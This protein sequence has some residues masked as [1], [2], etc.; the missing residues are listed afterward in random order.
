MLA[1]SHLI[2][3]YSSIFLLSGSA[4][5]YEVLLMRLFSIIHWHHFAYLIIGLALLGYGVSGTLVSLFQDWLNTRFTTIY[6]LAIMLFAVSSLGSFLLAQSIPFNAEVIFWDPWQWVYLA[7]LFLFL[8]IPFFFAATAICLAFM[9]FQRHTG[10]I[11]AADLVG[12]GT[13][14]LMIIALLFWLAPQQELWIISLIA[15]VAAAIP[16]SMIENQ[17]IPLLL[18]FVALI[19]VLF[20][21][22]GLELKMSPY[23]SLQQTLQITG[24]RL[25]YQQSSP[26]G[27]ID[28][29]ENDSVPFRAASGLS[30]NTP[31]EILP[32]KALFVDGENMTPLN[33]YDGDREPLV[34]L[35]FMTSALPYHLGRIEH[36]LIVG[37]GG[38]SDILQAAYH[39]VPDIQ[40][41]ERNHQVIE[42]VDQHMADYTGQPYSHLASKT[43]A[44]DVRDY[45]QGN[46]AKFDLIQMNLQQASASSAAGLH[47]INESYL[48]TKEAI[49]L[50]RS[51]L[52]TG[53]YLALTRWVTLPPRDIFKLINTLVSS[54]QEEGIDDIDK[55]MLIIRGW[56]TATLILKQ[57]QVTT[58]EIEQVK[59]F[60]QQRSFDLVWYPGI[61]IAETNR[62]NQLATPIFYQ[63]AK[64]LLTGNADAFVQGYK[65]NLEPATDNRPY[66][67]SY[68]KWDTFTELLALKDRGGMPL[69]EWAYLV[70]WAT[71]I[72][73]LI[74]S[75]ILI[76]LPLLIFNKKVHDYT[77]HIGKGSVVYYFMAIGLAFL[78]IEIAFIQKFMLL[79]HHPIYAIAISLSAFLVFA[80]VGSQF[81][82]RLLSW[83]GTQRLIQLTGFSIL[84][85]GLIYLWILPGV[86]AWSADSPIWG[87]FFMAI[88]L[89][90]PLAFLMGIPFPLAL[91]T[92]TR[93][94]PHY[95]PWAWGI[96]GC[97]SV[98]SAS[99]STII[100][101]NYGFNMV[102]MI[103]LM[104]Y[105]SITWFYPGKQFLRQ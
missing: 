97:A 84:T 67:H 29:V 43:H 42:I 102:I 21:G 13:G 10:A 3:I 11:Y 24:S 40:A 12:A 53:G 63:S 51:H 72:I 98:I 17:K 19:V 15:L 38:G 48:Y 49:K 75:V 76:L 93:H 103:A 44:K 35:D 104:I 2:A 14:S 80:G 99:L 69:M 86:F 105:L 82:Q 81:T 8:A 59:E 6:P 4:L 88:L 28:L 23:K 96:N 90:A 37:A 95:I 77:T 22:S 68:F 71:M 56:Q 30:L 9:R 34:Y 16:L 60:S 92:L 83:F 74:A 36:A 100:A 7:F 41:L 61:N 65:F 54:L 66:F 33:Q 5:A 89:I 62:F 85:I 18:L 91:S 101:I 1:R 45:L 78:M 57:G 64:Q 46:E 25:V 52:K 26:M 50:Y 20:L 58:H 39:Q 31:G 47:A 87:R 27:F 79:L 94:A 55:R 70:L 32:Q 73:A